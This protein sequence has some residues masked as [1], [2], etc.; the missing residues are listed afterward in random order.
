MFGW[1]RKR[2]REE[3]QKNTDGKMTF[4]AEQV[5]WLKR[6]SVVNLNLGDIIILSHPG[7]LSSQAY[8]NIKESAEFLFEGKYPIH[9]IEEGMQLGVLHP[10]EETLNIEVVRVN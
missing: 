2:K 8:A 9:I 1:F 6:Y 5:E 7:C 10:T 4:S 3:E